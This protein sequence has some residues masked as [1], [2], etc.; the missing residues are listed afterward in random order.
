MVTQTTFA[1]LK[2]ILQ[3]MDLPPQSC[4]AV[5]FEDEKDGQLFRQRMHALQA[6]KKLRSSGNGRLLTALYQERARERE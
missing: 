6:M 1:E 2:E 3:A 4:V 5:S